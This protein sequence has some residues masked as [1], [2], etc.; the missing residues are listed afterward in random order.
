M[1][2]NGISEICGAAIGLSPPVQ[3]FGHVRASSRQDT[4]LGFE[5]PRDT[6]SLSGTSPRRSNH[7]HEDGSGNKNQASSDFPEASRL[8]SALQYD[9]SASD[10]RPRCL[11]GCMMVP[12]KYDRRTSICMLQ[13][14]C[15][16][17]ASLR[18]VQSSRPRWRSQTL[19][20]TLQGR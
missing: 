6:P 13:G 8:A 16:E 2:N 15:G 9:A 1:L 7:S 17:D 11:L 20:R 4:D 19:H 3:V 5:G 18:C 10:N 12:G 14:T